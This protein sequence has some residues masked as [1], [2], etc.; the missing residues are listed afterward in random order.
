MKKI[1]NSLSIQKLTY[2]K[3]K[4]TSSFYLS[5]HILGSNNKI[6]KAIIQEN[7]NIIS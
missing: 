4:I 6:L 7:I 5:G 1:I 2:F 3:M